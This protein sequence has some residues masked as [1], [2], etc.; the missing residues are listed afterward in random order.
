MMNKNAKTQQR[1]R[2]KKVHQWK[3]ASMKKCINEKSINVNCI[4]EKLKCNQSKQWRTVI[5][6]VLKGKVVSRI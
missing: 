6:K 2:I 4:N 5:K 1:L 3:N